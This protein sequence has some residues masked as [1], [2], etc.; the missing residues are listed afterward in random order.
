M[1]LNRSS[2][3]LRQIIETPTRVTPRN[4]SILDVIFT[5]M[6]HLNDYEVLDYQVS[7]HATVFV[8]KKKSKLKEYCELKGLAVCTAAL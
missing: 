3:S 1:A 8:S 6:E 7:D 2:L 5:N 4:S